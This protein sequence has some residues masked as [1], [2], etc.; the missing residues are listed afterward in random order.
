[1]PLLPGDDGCC[2]PRELNLRPLVTRLAAQHLPSTR[3]VGQRIASLE[4]VAQRRNV[5]IYINNLVVGY[6]YSQG[7]AYRTGICTLTLAQWHGFALAPHILFSS[8]DPQFPLQIILVTGASGNRWLRRS[9]LNQEVG[10]SNP[11]G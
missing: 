2:H 6:G 1:M 7:G 11:A 10:G 5:K 3:Y 8:C 9:P 4:G